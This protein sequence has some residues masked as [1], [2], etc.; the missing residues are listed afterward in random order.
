MMVTWW[1]CAFDIPDSLRCDLGLAEKVSKSEAGG[2]KR[3][4]LLLL[5][6][7]IVLVVDLRGF[8]LYNIEQ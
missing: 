8:L 6:L 4:P 3:L 2:S 1:N 5:G 7:G